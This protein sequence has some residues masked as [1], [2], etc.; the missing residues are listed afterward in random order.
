MAP[1]IDKR[2]ELDI[3]VAGF[4]GSLAQVV[5]M[6]PSGTRGAPEYRYRVGFIVF[7]PAGRGEVFVCVSN[8][9]LVSTK[10][11][12]KA[13]FGVRFYNHVHKHAATFHSNHLNYLIL[14]VSVQEH[15]PA[16]V[17]GDVVRESELI[18]I[19]KD[20]DKE[21]NTYS[22]TVI[23]PENDACAFGGGRPPYVAL[24]EDFFTMGFPV[25]PALGFN[26]IDGAP[27]FDMH[28]LCVG[29]VHSFATVS[30]KDTLNDVVFVRRAVRFG[31]PEC[32]R[33]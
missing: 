12:K 16:V 8:K 2:A 30:R 24:D 6:T 7:A 25:L 10:L 4:S 23:I 9:L 26:Q 17:F 20:K 13:S 18:L 21:W 14:K 11:K 28:G 32:M 33:V 22:T 31:V 1:V 29:L 15:F 3:A 19:S 5:S 27:V